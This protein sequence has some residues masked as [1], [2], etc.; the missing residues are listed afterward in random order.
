MKTCFGCNQTKTLGEFY[1]HPQMKDGH[2][3][4]CK[5]CIKAD[6]TNQRNANIEKVRAYDLE[7][8]KR[9]E[10]RA[11]TNAYQKEYGLRNP[12]KIA[13][14]AKVD[15]AIRKGLLVR[16]KCERCE[17]TDTH[18]HHDDYTK[19]LEVR[20]LCP[21]HHKERHKELNQGE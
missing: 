13:A 16:G 11:K 19:P 3:N 17:R 6:A 12:E 18:G 9:P 7:R 15:S 1:T 14:Q 8:A 2:L 5:E 21:P 4:K 20:W 10:N